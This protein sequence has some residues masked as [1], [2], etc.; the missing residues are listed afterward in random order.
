MSNHI[1]D[2]SELP[3]VAFAYEYY[4]QMTDEWVETV[5]RSAEAIPDPETTPVRNLR[6]LVALAEAETPIEDATPM[7]VVPHDPDVS[8][9][10]GPVST[11]RTLDPIG[12][13]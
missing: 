8:E 11:G 3:V 10:G 2:Q 1:T 12:P 4:S 5:R 13:F 7:S 9:G 6:P